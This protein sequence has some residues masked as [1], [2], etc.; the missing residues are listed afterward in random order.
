MAVA[1][2]QIRPVAHLPLVLGVVR[3]LNVAALIETFCPPHPAHVLSCGRGVEALLLAILDGHHALYKVGARLEERGMLPLLQDGLGRASLNDYRLGQILDALFAANLN[4][5]FGAIAL[6]AL[7]VYAI[8]TPW[9]HQDTTTITL[10]GAYEE[11][12]RPVAGF[13]PPRPA[14]GHSKDGRDDLKQVLLSLGVSSDG[15]PLR[16]GLRDGNTSDSTETPVAIEE[17]VALGL[18]GVHGIVADSKA[19][20]KRTLGLCLEQRVGLITLVPRT[21]AVRQELEAWGQ[22]HGPM[23]LLLEKPGR[24]R[25]ESPRRWHG[26]SVV[27][28]VEVEYADGR[29]AEAALR[30][31]VVHSSQLAQQAAAAY[32]AAQ[33]KEAARVAEHIARVEARWFACAADAEAAIA[34]YEGRGQ[35]R[36]GRKPRP[37]RYH[38]LHYRVE[39]VSVPTKR[40]RRGRPPKAEAPQVEVRYRLGVRPE[41]VVPS[42]AAHGWTVLA[43]TVGPEE[44][45]DAE[46]LQAYQEQYTTVEPGFRWIKNPA[47]ISPVWLEKPERIAALAMLTVVGLLVYAVIQRQVRLYLHAHDQQVPGNKGPTAT[48]TAAV[49]FALFRPVMLAHFAVDNVTSLQVHGVEDHHR[50]VCEA[51]GIDPVW[52]QGVTTG[53]NS[54]PRTIPP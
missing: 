37:W 23:P 27:R 15:L 20:C 17:C 40:P 18:D 36:R 48:P 47:A 16:M 34:E 25:Q 30:F 5:V 7:A 11:E 42:E 39:A 31:L 21:C 6:H 10:Y 8:S 45:T 29:L 44:C 50:I 4:R 2:H 22:Q 51:V 43:T 28:R 33:A 32:T 1:I 41:A 3:K 12:A 13:V 35:G 53:Q 19:Y 46:M 54:P 38:D 24:T 49:V 14:Y 52:Y 26:R 9:L